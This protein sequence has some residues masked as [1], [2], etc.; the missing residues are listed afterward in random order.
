MNITPMQLGLI[1]TPIQQSLSPTLHGIISLHSPYRLDQYHLIESDL[2]EIDAQFRSAQNL[3]L[4]G[5]SVTIPLKQWAFHQS[6]IHSEQALLCGMVNALKW[7]QNGQLMGHNTDVYGFYRSLSSKTAFRCATILGAGG[8]SRAVLV[9]LLQLGVTQINCLCRRTEQMQELQA[10]CNRLKQ[11][12]DFSVYIG[13]IDTLRNHQHT[14]ILVLTMADLSLEAYKALGIENLNENL[15][16]YDINYGHKARVLRDYIKALGLNYQD[17]LLMLCHQGIKAFE[18]FFD[19]RFTP[20]QCLRIEEE[21][22]LKS[23]NT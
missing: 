10:F 13:H 23:R 1:G 20:E 6:M 2:T 12:F 15:L 16:V 18:W 5:M 7:D 21:F 11:S 3:A 19:L 4:Q 14:E 8:A 17:G 22:L 9:A